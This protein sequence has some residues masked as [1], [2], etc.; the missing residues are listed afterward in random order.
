MK[1]CNKMKNKQ[2]IKSKLTPLKEKL[3]KTTVKTRAITLSSWFVN[4]KNW[5]TKVSLVNYIGKYIDPKLLIAVIGVLRYFTK[6]TLYTNL[7]LAIIAYIASMMQLD[8]AIS[9]ELYTYIF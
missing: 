6:V 8:V 7:F 3:I 5:I 2:T 1:Q 4:Y 9:L